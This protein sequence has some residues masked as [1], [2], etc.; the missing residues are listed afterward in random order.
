MRNLF[1]LR[2]APASG[3]ST[4]IRENELEPYTISTDGLRLLY[5]SPVTTV[6]GDKAIS[7]NNDKQVF[8]LLMEILERR[9][10][11]GE[12]IIIDATHNKSKSINILNLEISE[13]KKINDNTV[14]NYDQLYTDLLNKY[15]KCQL[16]I[17]NNNLNQITRDYKLDE[18]L[19]KLRNNIYN[20][21]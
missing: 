15:E 6:E 21:Y 11:N 10:D 5:Q 1:I 9:M 7:Q 17:Q 4:W 20:K 13:I 18:A 19:I 8:N 14:N 16:D 12:L 2:G 3:K